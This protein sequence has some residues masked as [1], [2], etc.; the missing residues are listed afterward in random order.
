MSKLDIL[1]ELVRVKKL[2]QRY[3]FIKAYK[4][5][6]SLMDNVEEECGA[7]SYRAA[8]IREKELVEEWQSM[9]DD[10]RAGQ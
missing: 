6:Q 7:H 3:N 4:V 9:N 1:K 5:L 2:M 8:L 10:M